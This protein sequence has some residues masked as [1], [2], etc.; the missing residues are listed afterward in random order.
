MP[1]F[2]DHFKW[3]VALFIIYQ[4]YKVVVYRLSNTCFYL[5]NIKHSVVSLD[6]IID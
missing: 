6:M 1:R 4:K 5:V 3:N 2:E